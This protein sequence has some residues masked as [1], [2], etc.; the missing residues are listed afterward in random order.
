MD[1]SRLFAPASIAIVGATDRESSYGNTVVTNLLRAGFPGRLVGVH[2]KRTDVHGIKCIP[3]LDAID[4]PV[5]AVVIATPADT[6]PDIVE[7]AGRIGCGGAVVFAAEFSETGRTDRQEALVESAAKHSLPVIGPNANGIVAVHH[8]APMWGDVADIGEAGGVALITQSGNVGVTALASRRGLRWHTVVSV[9]NSAVVDASAALRQLATTDG[10]RSV[11]LYLEDDGNGGQWAEA[12]ARCAETNV[13]IAVLKAGRSEA[14]AVAGGAHTAAVAGDHRIFRSLIEEAGGAWCHD[15]HELLETA[16]LLATPRPTRAGGIAVVTCSGGDSVITADEADRLGVRLASLSAATHEKLKPLLP[17]GVVITNPL[18]HTNA[19]WAE[20]DAV[21]AVVEVLA[22]DDDVNQILYVQDTPVAM[23][24]SNT[25]EWKATRDGVVHAEIPGVTK[26][27]CAGLPELMPT[28]VADDLASFGVTALA[29]IPTA[30]RALG[31]HTAVSANPDR[32]R[33]I[34]RASVPHMGGHWLAE[35]DGKSLLSAHGVTV[36]EGGVA[37]SAVE[38]VALAEKFDGPIA[39]KVSHADIKHKTEIGGVILGMTDPTEITAAAE[40]LL[41]LVP[42]GVVLVEEMA[43]PGVEMLVSA[44]R[45]GIVP[46]LVVGLGGIW[47]ELLDD[48]AVIPLPAGAAR[49]KTAVQQLRG[50]TLLAGGRGKPPL[51]IDA[52]CQLAQSV[53]DALLR[54]NLSLVEINPVIVSENRA[55]A[56]D[57]V[58]Q[59]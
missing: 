20:T 33:A 51:A 54:E 17:D 14:G 18:D 27:V 23:P 15:P 34:A 10:V 6:V 36:P 8:R 16:K 26:A 24:E 13:R 45:D 57:A 58:V 4:S 19:L 41:S 49:I 50:Y 53:G 59:R 37:N 7:T 29:G 43:D 56:V 35:H 38:A 25:A 40:R 47:T 55:V 5:D 3:A 22:A 11:A 46:S 12:F 44:T 42:G 9:G 32:L 48:V 52:V 31:A 39:M 2:P 28:Y 1:L 21:K 30:L